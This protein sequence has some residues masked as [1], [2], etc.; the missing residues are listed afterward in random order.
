MAEESGRTRFHHG[1][2]AAMKVEYDLLKAPVSYD[3]E[4]ELGEE[5]V[6]L[7]FL[8][9][10]KDKNAVLS[11]PIGSFFRFVNLFEYKSPEDGLSIDG[12]L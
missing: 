4:T 5:P 8:I 10:K 3:Q 7:D 6:R 1:F 11:D 2:Y 9:V 12:F